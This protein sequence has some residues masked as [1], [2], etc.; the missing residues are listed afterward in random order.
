MGAPAIGNPFTSLMLRGTTPR[1]LIALS[2]T[3]HPRAQ[4][5][6]FVHGAP[7]PLP[8]PFPQIFA[9]EISANGSIGEP[10]RSVPRAENVEVEQCP[11]GTQLHAV[12]EAGRCE[13]L[14]RMAATIKAKRHSA[15][16]ALIR[17]R[18][19]VESDEFREVL[20]VVT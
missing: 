8:L 2:E 20:E 1:Q 7:L 16:S 10:G 6:C 13:A 5:S 18:Y 15:W 3:L 9:P 19:A 11:V 4:R 12:A 14:R 17:D